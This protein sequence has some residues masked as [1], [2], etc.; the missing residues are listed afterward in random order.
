M[1]VPI[2]DMKEWVIKEIVFLFFQNTK[3]I[4]S[5]IKKHFNIYEFWRYLKHNGKYLDIKAL[6]SLGSPPAANHYGW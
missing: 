1:S 6:K 4:Q 2:G 3:K 5:C